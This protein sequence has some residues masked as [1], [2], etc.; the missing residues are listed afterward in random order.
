MEELGPPHFDEAD[1]DFATKIRAT[2]TE[3][4]IASV[5]HTIGMDP[6]DRPLGDFLV[7]L[8]ARRK[9]ADRVRPMSAT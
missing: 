4:D 3:K 6:T 1:R 8:D 7:P 2:L 9:P 5:Y